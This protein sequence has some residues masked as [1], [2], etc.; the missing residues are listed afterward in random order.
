MNPVCIFAEAEWEVISQFSD[1]RERFKAI[2]NIAAQEGFLRRM[3]RLCILT[4]PFHD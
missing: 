2:A 3:C 1:F 4:S